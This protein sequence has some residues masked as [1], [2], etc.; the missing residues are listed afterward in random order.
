MCQAEECGLDNGL[1]GGIGGFWKGHGQ[2]C[3]R[4]LSLRQPVWWLDRR[5]ETE[6]GVRQGVTALTSAYHLTPEPGGRGPA[7]SLA[8]SQAGKTGPGP[9]TASSCIGIRQKAKAPPWFALTEAMR[10]GGMASKTDPL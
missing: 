2:M 3:I 8:C 7:Q 4:E 9:R 10:R 5:R 1:K 6:F